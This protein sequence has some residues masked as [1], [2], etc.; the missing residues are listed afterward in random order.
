MNENMKHFWVLFFALYSSLCFSQDEIKISVSFNKEKE[1]VLVNFR[2][3]S[4]KLLGINKGSK[5]TNELDGSVVYLSG[6]TKDNCLAEN[7]TFLWEYDTINDRLVPFDKF[8]WIS[9]HDHACFAI[10]LKGK[11]ELLKLNEIKVQIRFMIM[12]PSQKQ[13]KKFDIKII[14]TDIY[15]VPLNK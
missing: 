11:D 9:N 6:I 7:I 13:G 1:L 8:T 4:D 15:E 12:M 5:G 10:L 3:D 14:N 2:N